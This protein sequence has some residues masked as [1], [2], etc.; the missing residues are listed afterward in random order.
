MEVRWWGL[1]WDNSKGIVCGWKVF[2]GGLTESY[3]LVGTNV[4]G[5][6]ALPCCFA[7]SFDLIVGGL[8]LGG[9]KSR[10]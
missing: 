5:V 6:F 2:G 4:P 7:T 9:S 8:E 1:P 3:E 10:S